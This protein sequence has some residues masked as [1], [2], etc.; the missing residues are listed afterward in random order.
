MAR[1]PRPLLNPVLSL[2]MEPQPQTSP[3]RGK[4]LNAIRQERLP[5]QQRVLAAAARS[6]FE[7]RDKLPAYGGRIHFVADMAEDSLAPTHT[8]SDLFRADR[9][10][11]IVAPLRQGYLVEA[12][13]RALPL[14]ASAIERPSSVPEQCDIA[15]VHAMSSFGQA[16]R[17][18]E[19]TLDELWDAA[20]EVPNGRQF[21]IWLAPFQNPGSQEALL[22]QVTE[23]SN[24]QIILSAYTTVRLI[25]EG[26]DAGTEIVATPNQSSVAQAMRSYRNTGIG[27]ATVSVP[28]KRALS[29]LVA[30]GVSHRIDPVRRIH[31]T[32]PGDGAE[33]TPPSNLANAPIVGVVDGGLDARSYRGAEAWRI[34]PPLVPDGVADRPHGN[35]VTS[36]VVQGHAWNRNRLLPQLDCRVGVVQAVARRKA[37]HNLNEQELIG[38]LG[39]AARAHPETHVWNISANQDMSDFND[40]EVSVLGHELN[41]LA[42]A[43][44]ILP[45]ISVG[46]AKGA[47]AWPDPPADCD[48]AI[49]V[50]GRLADKEGRPSDGCPQCLPGPGPEGMLK[51]DLS[52]FSTLRMI[53][54]TIH[55]GSSYSSAITSSLAAHTQ[56]N[57]RDPSPDLVKALLINA[58]EQD[59]HDARLGWGTPYHGHLPWVCQPGSVTLTW[60]AHMQPG[61]AYHWNNI[62][63]PPE[64]V[65]NGKLYGRASLTAILRPL[66]SPFGGANYY[67]SRLQTSLRYQDGDEWKAL[68]GSM[69][70]ST[71]TEAEAREDLKK[72]QPVRR[73]CRDFMK[74]SGLGFSGNSFQLYAR[75]F[76][77]DLY[78]FK[79]KHH[80]EAGP[81]EAAF[82]LS[83][84]A[85]EGDDGAIYNSMVQQL[86]NFV[87]SGVVN[88]E[89]DISNA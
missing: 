72:W 39:A 81:Q 48:A 70:E 67:A 10:F 64:L 25:G 22:K 21:V 73:H 32:A 50:G 61:A 84:T 44:N 9:G 86:G 45:V 80:S 6:L 34:A 5:R 43:A 76:T 62:P 16:R 26:P 58:S 56:A 66:V 89:I 55:T 49:V 60:R 74:R 85:P 28:N 78:Q 87:Q 35:A 17:L 38:Y 23:L 3:G 33:P 30:S 47:Q 57:L 42:R 65:R 79:W 24:D 36:L 52:W 13:V 71:L 68:L 53:G 41:A 18:R 11:Q 1:E 19:H 63:I 29:T 54:G 27:R 46:N 14:L 37:G 40:D 2:T 20:P 4:K 12:D 75:V 51:P 15:S 8:P 69:K 77:R 83:L 82:V 59:A 7:E 88:Q 31:V